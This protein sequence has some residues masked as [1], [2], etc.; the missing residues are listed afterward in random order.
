[1]VLYAAIFNSPFSSQMR[2]D[3]VMVETC[4]VAAFQMTQRSDKLFLDL[5]G[6]LPP[7][8][9]HRKDWNC[10]LAHVQLGIVHFDPFGC[11]YILHIKFLPKE[12]LAYPVDRLAHICDR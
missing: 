1:M 2:E 3:L 12:N 6:C 5:L 10:Y 7:C 4:V 8:Y 9:F 11:K